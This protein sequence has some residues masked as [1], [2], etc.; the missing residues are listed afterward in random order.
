MADVALRNIIKRYDDI[1][2][3][4]GI[5]LEIPDNE[6]VVLVGPSGC[7][8][9]TTLRMIAGLEEV[10]AGDIYIGGEIV[11]DRPPKDRD[12]AMVF[13]NYALYPHMSAFENMSFGLKLRKFPK[14]EI[15]RRVD[16]AARILDITELLDRK[17]KALSGGQRQRVAMGRA[18]VRDPKV[19]LF[20]E[21]LS[22]LDA[23][24]RV[25][26]RT[27]IKRVHQ[28]VKTTTVYVTHD[29]VEAMTLADRVV[30]MNDG[31]IEQIAT[32]QEL[33]HHPKTRF[34]AGFI[35][36]PAMNLMRCRLEQN[37]AGLRVRLS[38]AISLPVPQQQ[39]ARYQ[40][41]IG[42]ELIF[43][44]R[45]EHITER[46][47]SDGDQLREFAATLDV[48]EPMGME[49]MVYFTVDG[50]EICGRVDPG[51]AAGPGQSMQLCANMDHMH[52]ID[53]Q[54]G[55]VL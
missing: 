11:N 19:F 24:L 17:P 47:R 35:G 33:Y 18:I 13:Q 21:P 12:I 8:K 39:S 26:M 34:V 20:D 27:E 31:R 2:A 5:N 55:A 22:N 3:V 32:P 36:S 30:V 48:V 16:H 52:L 49:T 53:S 6:F 4:R 1:E 41:M 14:D 42:K 7:G 54:S 51:S 15:R 25:Q 45:P 43:G 37:G 28:M 44:L 50:Q 9:S 23:K 46:R 40:T 29:Q 38:D 10:T